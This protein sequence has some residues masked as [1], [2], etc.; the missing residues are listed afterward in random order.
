MASSE[1]TTI[2][3]ALQ[4]GLPKILA[5]IPAEWRGTTFKNQVLLGRTEFCARLRELLLSKG[6]AEITGEDL[7]A[8]GNAEDYLRV[9]S[10]VSSLLEFSLAVR[11]GV[12]EVSG[13]FSFA[14]RVMPLMAMLLTTPAPATVHLLLN[15][16]SC[17]I[18]Q[19]NLA[20]LPLLNCRLQLHSGS[21][22]DSHDNSS[23]ENGVIVGWSEDLLGH[24]AP[25]SFSKVHAVAS[26]FLL[27]I[28]DTGKVDPSRVLVVRKR[29]SSPLTT[30]MCEA[31]LKSFAEGLPADPS[32]AG[33]ESEQLAGFYEHL[34]TMSGADPAPEHPP[35]CCTSGL[36]TICSVWMALIL[37]QGGADVVMASTAYG[38]S[39]ELTDL[40][41]ARGANFRKHTFDI[42]GTNPI[43][44]AIQ[45]AFDK[46]AEKGSEGLLP[47]TVL[48]V[49]IPTNPD[50]K[51]PELAELAAVLEGYRAATGKRVLLLLD[52]TFAPSSQAMAKLAP[53]MPNVTLLTFI[54]LSKSVS[55]G[56]TTDGTVV[57]ASTPAAYEL[58]EHVRAA[59]TLLDTSAKPDQLLV[60]SQNHTGVE[61]R[62]QRAYEVAIAVGSALREAV[63]QHCAGYD[64]PLAFVTPAQASLGFSSSTFS[65][66]LPAIAGA[67]QSVNESLAQRFV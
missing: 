53:L 18:S 51:V 21:S 46:L 62:C 16:A 31:V 61:D 57:A 12:E 55:R 7:V 40:L 42:T 17:P 9:S 6:Y 41:A 14:S 13:V 4:V 67:S 20:L 44:P 32:T 33:P 29:M 48:F 1:P 45:G 30:P 15:G 5:A 38:G 54:S 56:L 11:H 10:N 26:P 39:S 64:M 8:L 24:E 59:A 23:N 43:T 52:T 28:R 49:E 36:A 65:F 60:L 2:Q 19:D 58:L 37:H 27:L 22:L 47:T 50:M 34:Q 25:L 66:N 35:V 3:Q 63:R